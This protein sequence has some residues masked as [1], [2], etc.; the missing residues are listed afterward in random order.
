MYV[1]SYLGKTPGCM[2]PEIM[3]KTKPFLL[4]KPFKSVR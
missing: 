1:F 4:E 2:F 3:G